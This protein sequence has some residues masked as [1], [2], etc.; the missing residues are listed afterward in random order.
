MHTAYHIAAA[1]FATVVRKGGNIPYLSHLLAVLYVVM[2]F[3]F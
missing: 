1:E 3:V 2:L